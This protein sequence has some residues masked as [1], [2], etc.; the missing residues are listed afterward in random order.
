VALS[1]AMSGLSGVGGVCI[2]GRE[3]VGGGTPIVGN[4][5]LVQPYIPLA[6]LKMSKRTTTTK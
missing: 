3:L 4:A 6:K 1:G 5:V 2:A